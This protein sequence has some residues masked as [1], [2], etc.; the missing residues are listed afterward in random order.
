MS[1]S[2]EPPPLGPWVKVAGIGGLVI[3]GFLT[4]VALSGIADLGDASGGLRGAK[5]EVAYILAGVGMVL[6][7]TGFATL[8]KI[9]AAALLQLGLIS[10]A[11]VAFIKAG[12]WSILI[13]LGAT[14][15]AA[16]TYLAAR[17]LRAQSQWR[18]RLLED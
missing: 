14:A 16:A 3:G 5:K 2:L 8:Q 11:A 1:E 15:V 6:L 9:R 18:E 4:A 17:V 7:A 10:L 12:G 13:G